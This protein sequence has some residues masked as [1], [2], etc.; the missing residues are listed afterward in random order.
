MVEHKLKALLEAAGGDGDLAGRVLARKGRER[1]DP[2]ESECCLSGSHYAFQ[3]ELCTDGAAQHPQNRWLRRCSWAVVQLSS[4][5]FACGILPARVLGTNTVYEAELYAL[6]YAAEHAMP[7]PPG[8]L[9]HIDNAEVVR[10]AQLS[11]ASMEQHR[12][13]DLWRRL[14]VVRKH[15]PVLVRKIKAHSACPLQVDAA[16]RWRGNDRADRL[17]KTAL[18]LPEVRALDSPREQC[19]ALMREAL[20]R[21]VNISVDNH[22]EEEALARPPYA[23]PD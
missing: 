12:H 21:A 10:G 22:L 1:W 9:V 7:G 8:I 15:T 18:L 14:A 13:G 19:F 4:K 20:T 16:W 6:V 2:P 11:D 3:G 5:G 23:P 17:A